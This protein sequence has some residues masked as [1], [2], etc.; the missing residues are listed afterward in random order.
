MNMGWGFKIP[1][2]VRESGDNGRFVNIN[3]YDYYYKEFPSNKKDARH[4]LLLHGF[5]GS[6]YT[7][8][9]IDKR[10]NEEGYHVWSLD[11]KGFGWSDKPLNAKYDPVSI[12]EDVRSWLEFMNL[13]NITVV[14]NS[15]GGGVAMLL[16]LQYPY[17]VDRLVL[18][19]PGALR[20]KLPAIMRLV[21]MPLSEIISDAI[22]GRWM[23]RMLLREVMYD[24][25]LITDEQVDNYFRR[26]STPNAT[27]V[28]VALSRAIDFKQLETYTDRIGQLDN[29]TLILWGENDRWIPVELSYKL[30][31][32]IRNS[33]LVLI[34]ECGHL[35]QEEKPEVVLRHLLAFMNSTPGALSSIPREKRIDHDA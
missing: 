27:V 4:I 33:R 12:T 21:R 29:D 15:Y 17:L 2:Q 6:T 20:M 13:N 23:V 24:R 9:K 1:G 14:G 32:G 18:L 25:G 30:F 31:D 22:F 28:Q 35:P 19:D 26:M 8:E 34:K 3:G 10:L 5:A 11:M 16:A 7:W